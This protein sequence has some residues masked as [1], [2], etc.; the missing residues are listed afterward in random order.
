M[1]GLTLRDTLLAMRL[2]GD[3]GIQVVEC[4]V[5]LL[6]AVPAALVHALDLFVTAT[7]ALVLL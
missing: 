6:T 7:R 5:G 4:A 1:L 3:M 2:H